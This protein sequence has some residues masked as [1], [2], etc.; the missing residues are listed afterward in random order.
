M[1]TKKLIHKLLRTLFPKMYLFLLFRYS[2]GYWPNIK[3][4]TRI[5]EYIFN[6]KYFSTNEKKDFVDKVKVRDIVQEVIAQENINLNLIEILPYTSENTKFN[7][8]A[9]NEKCFIKGNNG[10]GMNILFDPKN[11]DK[12]EILKSIHNWNKVEYDKVFGEKVYAGI[13]P[14]VYCERV[15]TC[16]DGFIP[17]DIK[18]HC[19]KGEPFMIQVIRRRDGYIQRKTYDRNWNQQNWFYKDDLDFNVDIKKI[20]KDDLISIAKKL[21]NKH[22]YVRID[23]Y[24]ANKK[25]YFGEFTF[26]P[27]SS[28]LP[29]VSNKV[30]ETLF[31]YCE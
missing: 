28:H 19:C 29:L 1:G 25:I 22:D 9:I 30:D 10:C 14:K 7:L 20:P 2:V 13:K 21:S 15:L 8:D 3:S 18:I 4:P 31:K 11:Y 5:R 12:K 26:F 16:E 6:L 17:D 24:Y 27:A 23:L